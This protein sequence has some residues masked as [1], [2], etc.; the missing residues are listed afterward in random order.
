MADRPI[1]PRAPID[2]AV[3]T[4]G[5]EGLTGTAPATVF[6]D[7]S[8]REDI[9]IAPDFR[10][11]GEQPAW[12]QDF[13]IDWPQ[14]HYVERRDF[15]KF[16]TLTSFAFAVGQAW[17]AVQSWARGASPAPAG[18]RI[19][20]VSDIAIGAS[21]VFDFPG[22]HDPCVLVRVADNHFVAY[23]QKCTHLSCAVI[24]RPAE[25]TLLCPCHE[26]VFDLASGRPLAGPPRRPLD[27]IA[28]EI[29]GGAVYATA[30]ERRTV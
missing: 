16:L 20:A 24:P 28:L 3:R 6:G 4:A 8:P 13:P 9:T 29:R 12:R 25:K 26:G 10:P 21:L 30:V 7:L 5:R 2:P 11:A 27:R 23:G 19:A 18:R 17:I 14:D 22:D 15:M 1:D